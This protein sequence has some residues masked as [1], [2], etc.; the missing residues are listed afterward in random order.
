[1]YNLGACL[2]EVVLHTNHTNQDDDGMFQ[3]FVSLF[4]VSCFFFRMKWHVCTKK[5]A[6]Y[7]LYF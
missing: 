3:E 5:L 1:M 6:N 4:V 7:V 2:V